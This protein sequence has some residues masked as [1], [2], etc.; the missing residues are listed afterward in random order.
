MGDLAEIAMLC[1]LR[2]RVAIAGIVQP[3][4]AVSEYLGVPV[5]ATVAELGDVD[6]V[7]LTEYQRPQH[8]YQDLTADYP[9]ER[10]LVPE[11]LRISP[12]GFSA[13]KQAT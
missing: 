2:H 7:M 4:A 13:R 10:V 1:S 5:A 12:A 6:G 8:S 11:V 3:R 9:A